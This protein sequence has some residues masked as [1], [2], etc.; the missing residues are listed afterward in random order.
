VQPSSSV[1]VDDAVFPAKYLPDFHYCK[2]VDEVW[3]ICQEED[4]DSNER[5]PTQYGPAAQV[6]EHP[7]MIIYG[8]SGTANETAA[9]LANSVRLANQWYLYSNGNITIQADVNVDVS[10]LSSM[11]LILFG[12]PTTNSVTQ[13]VQGSLPVTFAKNG[14]FRIGKKLFK[15]PKTGIQFLAPWNTDQLL[16]VLAGTDAEGDVLAFKLMPLFSGMTLPDYYVCGVDTLWQ[17]DGGAIAAGYW[18]NHWEFL[19]ETGYMR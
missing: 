17:G 13:Q 16:L 8:T 18:G 5:R 15:S 12:G 7:V 10:E 1:T 6:F 14:Q 9:Y 3:K 11:S 19:P 2:F 4:W